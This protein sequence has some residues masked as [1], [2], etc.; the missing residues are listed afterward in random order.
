MTGQSIGYVRVSTME[1]STGRQTDALAFE[2]IEIDKLFIEKVSAKDRNRP[3]LALCIDYAREGDTIYVHSI[4]RLARSLHDLEDI[5]RG[6]VSKGVTVHF[7]KGSM[8]YTKDNANPFSMMT[9]RILGIFAEFER[10]IMIER[11][12]EGI[13]YAKANGT[14]T[15]KPFGQQPL[16]MRLRDEALKLKSE[17]ISNRKIALTMKISRPSVAKLLSKNTDTPHTH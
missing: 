16:D 17:G 2:G 3:Q 14:K 1:Q 12:R 9:L 11:Q 8:I 15:G 13:A 4:D 6:L 5:V 7:I 10:D